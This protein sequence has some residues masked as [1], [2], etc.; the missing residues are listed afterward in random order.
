MRY[1]YVEPP[2]GVATVVELMEYNDVTQG[3]A[4]FV[5]DAADGW[6]GSDPIRPL[7]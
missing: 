4:K 3:L 7:N 2:A 6:D 1:A 5:R